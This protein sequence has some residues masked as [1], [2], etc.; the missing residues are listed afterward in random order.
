MGVVDE[1]E[2]R[3]AGAP[4]TVLVHPRLVP[5]LQATFGRH[6]EIVGDEPDGRRRVRVAAQSS[7]AVAEQL[8]GWATMVEVVGPPAVV[9]ELARIG[10]E[11]VDRYGP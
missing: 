4:A 11:L 10:A 1:V 9:A 8:A 7:T 3:R 2:Q 6:A 5:G